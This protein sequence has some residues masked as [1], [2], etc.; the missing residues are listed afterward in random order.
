MLIIKVPSTGVISGEGGG[1]GVG[2]NRNL[3]PSSSDSLL[4]PTAEGSISSAGLH[5]QTVTLYQPTNAGAN[6][7]YNKSKGKFL[8]SAVSSSQD[9][10]NVKRFTLYF[11]GRPVHSDT[12]LASLGSIQPYATNN[13]REGCSYTYP[14]LSMIRYSYS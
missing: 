12:N 10:S 2:A 14:P 4:P 7:E 9:H 3:S 1:G 5:L 13:I 11:P 8:Y 6:I